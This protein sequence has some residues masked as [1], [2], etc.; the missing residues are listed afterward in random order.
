MSQPY[1]SENNLPAIASNRKLLLLA[2]LLPPSMARRQALPEASELGKILISRW[3]QLEGRVW[4]WRLRESVS[5]LIRTE[6]DERQ[7]AQAGEK[8]LVLAGEDWD[9]GGRGLRLE[10][11]APA[12]FEPRSLY[13]DLLKGGAHSAFLRSRSEGEIAWSWPL[14][15][16]V[17]PNSELLDGI[18]PNSSLKP[19]FQSF[20]YQHAS[21]RAHLLLFEGS[22]SEVNV[23]IARLQRRPEADAVIVFGGMGDVQTSDWNSLSQTAAPTSAQGIFIFDP[24]VKD[25]RSALVE[26][27]IAFL[28][29][30]LPLDSAVARLAREYGAP[31]VSYATRRLV[32]ATSVREQGR[33]LARRLKQMPDV[34]FPV[35][36][37]P[38]VDE[39]G[40]DIYRSRESVPIF[41]M[42]VRSSSSKDI[43]A[44]ELGQELERQLEVPKEGSAE[45]GVEAES[46]SFERESDGAR[47]LADLA[48]AVEKL[49]DE[50]A[51]RRETRY[52]QAR[53]ETP[54]GR[55]I[56]G[57]GRLLPA[58]EYVACVFI[59]ARD[60]K[61]LAVPEPLKVPE[62]VDNNPI[63]LDVMFWEPHASPQPQIAQL[64]L[65]PQG[66][67]GI[68]E[69]PFR[70]TE[71]QSIFSA[72]IAVYHRN[73]NLQTGLLKGNV[74][75]EPAQL[76][77]TLDAAPTPKFV[78]LADRSGVGA[79][80]ILNEDP[81]G[82]G[83]AFTYCNGQASVT[84]VVD[85]DPTQ[86]D[87][88]DKLTKAL[89][90]AIT[91]I[92]KNPDD[93]TDLSKEGSRTL[94]LNLALRGSGLLKTLRKHTLMADQFDRV[95]YI[96]IVS[97]HVGSFFP[98]EYLYDGEAPEN[99]AGICSGAPAEQAEI[100][101]DPQ[102]ASTAL[103]SG[104][105]CGAYDKSPRRT[106]CPLRF[107]SLNK[108][109]ERHAH[110]AE[111]TKLGA[112]FQ[113]RSASVSAR[114]RL[115]DPLSGGVLA[116]SAVAD[117]AVKDTVTNLIV[118][119]NR[120]LRK[121]VVPATNWA[122]WARGI[123]ETHPSLLVLLPHHGQ[124]DG[125][126][127]LEIGGDVRLSEQIRPEHVRAL[128][129]PNTRPIVLLIGCDT[130]ASKISLEN[131]VATFQDLGAVIIVSTIATILGRQAGPAAAAIV[132]E[133]KKQ[134][135]NINATFGDVMLK[136]RRRLLAAGTPM[137]LGLTSY[138][139][140]DW[141]IG[142]SPDEAE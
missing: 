48:I 73:R 138:G 75:N 53:V 42:K 45:R 76:T 134:E 78:G 107:W 59:G 109:I 19:L 4:P 29:H 7:V 43:N 15:I 49:S 98:I 83:Q 111:H 140:A 54:A 66:N 124:E 123:S 94:L 41:G 116:A 25:Q 97:A 88:L 35:S 80:I 112:Q 3:Q 127:S 11:N 56:E 58:R 39:K 46:L 22:L 18:Y 28:S 33:I 133:I 117:A 142:R 52:L 114:N 90:S 34:N 23:T 47:K 21:M 31:V 120:A 61:W 13:E 38:H 40:T 6:E 87:D 55:A 36:H 106:I 50:E 12:Q 110:L 91:R 1:R 37:K 82:N 100:S 62:P 16:G 104:T 102:A 101:S 135:G 77:F 86:G 105:C 79:S 8:L 81:D 131:F 2:G 129:D 103:D 30:D 93:Y 72:R 27:L 85:V 10:V 71:N 119:L 128:Q 17:A 70:T 84:K 74:G 95:D 122:S 125:F 68:A 51:A 65:L 9:R 24:P 136:V 141:R 121:E 64:T 14:R 63:L 130:N 26:G 69:F 99:E 20:D 60:L 115:L 108:V 139:D 5:R 92:T 32:E 96:Q 113:L 132:E 67:T 44:K 137:V 89:G 118:Q 57:Q 126:D